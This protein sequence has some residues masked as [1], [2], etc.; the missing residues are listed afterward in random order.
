MLTLE[1][2]H[3]EERDQQSK[4]RVNDSATRD[5]LAK[6]VRLEVEKTVPEAEKTVAETKIDC[7][8]CM[9]SV[10]VSRCPKV[11]ESCQHENLVCGEC[12]KKSC[13]ADLNT[14]GELKVKSHALTI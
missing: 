2:F 8:V 7:R 1:S 9:K 3:V 11:T 14:K 10:E 5:S 13:E 12:M 6:K 4:K